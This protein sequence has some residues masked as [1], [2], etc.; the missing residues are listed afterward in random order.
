[1]Q[2]LWNTEEA[3]CGKRATITVGLEVS[4]IGRPAMPDVVDLTDQR[5]TILRQ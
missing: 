4:A 2:R 5:W 1:M 3:A